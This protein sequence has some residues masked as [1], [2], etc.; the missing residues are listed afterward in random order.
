MAAFALALIVAGVAVL[1]VGYC[2]SLAMQFMRC[3][4]CGEPM[5]DGYTAT[6]AAGGYCRTCSRKMGLRPW[7]WKSWM[8]D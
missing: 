2:R 6:D 5:P 4:G 1:V 3:H 7:Y 8:K